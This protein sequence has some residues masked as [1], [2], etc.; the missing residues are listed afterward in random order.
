MSLKKRDF[1]KFCYFLILANVY[2]GVGMPHSCA[3]V[4]P[5]KEG[6]IQALVG[7]APSSQ[8]VGSLMR[9]P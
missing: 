8:I 1:A 5:G 6:G 4:Y 2:F 7:I 3:G 9:T